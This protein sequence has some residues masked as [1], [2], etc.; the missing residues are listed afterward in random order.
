MVHGF[1]RRAL[2]KKKNKKRKRKHILFANKSFFVFFFLKDKKKIHPTPQ[3]FLFGLENHSTR[4]TENFVN[5]SRKK[6]KLK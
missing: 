2:K 4:T 1:E 3:Y 5:E 6:I